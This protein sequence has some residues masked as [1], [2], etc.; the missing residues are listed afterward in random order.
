ML[1]PAAG[2]Y[3]RS[4]AGR[5]LAI[6]NDGKAAS[7]LVN[8]FFQ[9]E[10]RADLWETALTIE[11]LDDA[12]V[13]LPLI[14]AL[15]DANLQRRHAAARALGWNRMSGSREARALVRILTDAAQP[16]FIRAEAAESLAYLYYVPSIPALISALSD[17]DADIRF[18]SV[19][20]LGS[21][22]HGVHEADRHVVSAL[23]ARLADDAVPSGNWWSIAR[24]ALAML[25]GMNPAMEQYQERLAR[26]AQRVLD[27]PN[28]SR[29]DRRWAESHS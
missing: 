13:L 12:T 10:E 14:R 8:Q 17:P 22:G 27:D 21:I 18:W 23:E 11:N 29:V 24:E 9:Q 5:I 2:W 3:V 19:F 28:S 1:D 20:A 7:A 16:Q 25:G 6:A 26:E 4:A 15:E